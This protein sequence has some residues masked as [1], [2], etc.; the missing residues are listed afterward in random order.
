MKIPIIF[1]CPGCDRKLSCD[2]KHSGKTLECP[3]CSREFKVPSKEKAADELFKRTSLESEDRKY[4][5]WLQSRLKLIESRE[6]KPG[7]PDNPEDAIPQW[8]KKAAGGIRKSTDAN[9]L[10][11]VDLIDMDSAPE[12]RDG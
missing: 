12:G 9:P 1:F 10:D 2:V 4:A 3:R 8:I 7:K 5:L 6:R 11:G